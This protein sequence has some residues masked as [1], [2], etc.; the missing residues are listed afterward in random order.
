MIKVV[1][2]SLLIIL[3]GVVPFIYFTESFQA[4]MMRGRE[5]ETSIYFLL[6]AVTSFLIGFL[7]ELAPF[8]KRIRIIKW[9]ALIPAVIFGVLVVLNVPHWFL[10]SRII[11]LGYGT[12]F[13]I[14]VMPLLSVF[15][16]ILFAKTIATDSVD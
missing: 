7:F 5:P 1:M 2:S 10:I 15:M 11:G 3:A 16:G 8:N 13:V 4:M 9:E 14:F 6:I 12:T